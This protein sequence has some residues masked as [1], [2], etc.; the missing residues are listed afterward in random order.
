[1]IIFPAIDLI[2][3]KCVRLSEGDFDRVKEYKAD[4]L[5]MAKKYQDAGLTHLHLVDLDGARNKKVSQYKV[6][7]LIAGKTTLRVDFGGGVQSDED[8]RIVFECGAKQA[9]V[10]SMAVQDP[11]LFESW[12]ESYG[13]ELIIFAADVRDKKLATHAWKEGGELELFDMI[14]RFKSKTLSLLTCTDISRDGMLGGSN[15]EL[16]TEILHTYPDILL[17]ASGGVHSLEDLETLKEIGCYGAIVG[18]AIYENKIR[19]EDLHQ[20]Q[21]R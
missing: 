3:G 7:E 5:D 8:L 21:S 19:I 20:F 16:Y 9:N 4:P 18:K 17:T 14:E 11:E 1:M 15:R 12:L 13:P 2:D 10:G 6:L